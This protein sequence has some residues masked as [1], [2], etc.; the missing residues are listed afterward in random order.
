MKLLKVSA[1]CAAA[2][3]ALAGC[4]KNEVVN[5]LIPSDME[6]A[7]AKVKIS[8]AGATG[9]RAVTGED[10]D[11]GETEERVVNNLTILL[12]DDSEHVVGVGSTSKF[13][14]AEDQGEDF[15]KRTIEG[16]IAVTLDPGSAKPSKLLAFVNS[17]ETAFETLDEAVAALTSV[18]NTDG[19]KFVMTNSLGNDY[20]IATDVV[21]EENFASTEAGLEENNKK[22]INIFVERLAAKITV[23]NQS[24]N[25]T[26]SV[27]FFDIDEKEYKIVFEPY[28][29]AATGTTRE[30][31]AFKH[32][33]TQFPVWAPVNEH[34]TNWAYGV[35]YDLFY[36]DYVRNNKNLRY[37]T[38]NQ[39]ISD[40]GV[41]LDPNS[42]NHFYVNEHT[43][44]KNAMDNGAYAP[45]ITGTNAIIVGQYKVIGESEDADV[46]KFK[47]E[48]GAG[49]SAYDFYV[50]LRGSQYTI[51]NKA[52]LITYLVGNIKVASDAGG[53]N[54]IERKDLEKYFDLA[55]EK[56]NDKYVLDLKEEKEVY[57][58]TDGET[59]SKV[60]DAATTFGSS[61]SKHYKFGW[62][63]FLAPIEHYY[64]ED[65]DVDDSTLGAYGVVRN[66]SYELTIKSITGLG[67]PLDEG[68]IGEDPKGSDPKDP[69]DPDPDPEDPK[70][71][72]DDPIIPD[73]DDV[74]TAYIDAT[75]NILWWHIISQD[76]NL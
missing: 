20:K 49:E 30:M 37:L 7:Y 22:A 64:V 13:A 32:G 67:A 33:D 54:K 17:D 52:D 2:V 26:S 76:V 35:N 10:Y 63:Y 29:W 60:E 11:P 55:E 53:A 58:S 56:I 12:F 40:N 1:L 6:T 34:R 16:T 41:G 50:A 68:K 66:H 65:E 8:M 19:K 74:K 73:P 24:T 46:E 75:L 14:T 38:A 47:T 59:W 27:R 15:N 18:T 28:K 57:Y 44:G 4:N 36:N 51:Y 61:N 62:A 48:D 25:N 9:T 21:F 69:D 43:F 42:S 70:D 71:P 72:G 45:K 3:I 39:I 23:N 31:Y 5:N